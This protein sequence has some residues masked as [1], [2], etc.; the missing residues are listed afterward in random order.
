MDTIT[1]AELLV[2][3]LEANDISHVFNIPGVGVFPFVDALA[4]S[5]LTYVGGVNETA[6]GLIAEGYS[7]AARRPGFVNVYHSSGTALAMVALTV[8]WSDRTPLVFASTT[9]SRQLRGRDQYAAVPDDITDTAEQYTKWSHTVTSA[10]RVPEAIARAVTVATTPPMGPVHLALPMDLYREEVDESIVGATPEPVDGQYPSSSASTPTVDETYAETTV[11]GDATPSEAGLEA[12]AALLADAEA[13]LIAAGGDVGQH[14]ATDELVALAERL[15][16]GVVTEW[17]SPTYLPMPTDHPLYLGD[18]M[19]AVAADVDVFADTD[20]ILSVGF[21]FTEARVGQYPVRQ[22]HR[23]VHLTTDDRDIGKQVPDD[24]GLV[25]HPRPALHRLG[26]LLEDADVGDADGRRERVA[27][28][29]EGIQAA[30]AAKR[31]ALETDDRPT[32]AEET[33]AGLRDVFGEDLLVVNYAVMSG[34]YVDAL[35]FEGPDDFYAISGKA[36]AQGWAAP[37]GIGVQLAEPDRDVVAINGDG[38]FMFTSPAAMYTAAYYDVPLTVIVLNNR[39]WGGGTYDSILENEWGES[40][41]IGAFDDPPLDFEMLARGVGLH[42]ERIDSVEAV[43][44]GLRA[45]RDHDGPSL[46]EVSMTFG[47]GM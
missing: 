46:V 4:E 2:D 26:T 19:D 5:D 12:A 40:G 15:G 9:T 36:S 14:Y 27:T 18:V 3:S 22:D 44:A 32:P 25:G 47:E 1:G 29:A 39:G 23:V 10:R 24:V 37:A 13:P 42:Y 38:G 20:V 28:Y 41:L 11:Y 30:V 43:E 45:A 35:D 6:V 31:D 33:V 7:R 17:R 8:A 34:A 16:A 21:E